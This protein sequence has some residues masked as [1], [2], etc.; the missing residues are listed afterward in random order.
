MHYVPEIVTFSHLVF[1]QLLLA[2][3]AASLFM[4][5]SLA[6]PNIHQMRDLKL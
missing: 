6:K 4:W 1:V 5:A 2:T 3:H